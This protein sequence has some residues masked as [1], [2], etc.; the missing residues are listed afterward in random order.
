[1]VEGTRP[2]TQDGGVDVAGS[3]NASTV[4]G[5]LPAALY[6]PR[7]ENDQGGELLYVS[8]GLGG[9]VGG[10]REESGRSQEDLRGQG[11]VRLESGWSQGG[12]REVL[13]AY[14]LVAPPS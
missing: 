8:Q 4:R 5:T 6:E 3:P 11:G 1:M 14:G 10:I 12:I 7:E 9:R 13:T 2:W